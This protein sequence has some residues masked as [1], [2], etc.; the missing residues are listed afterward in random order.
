MSD[1]PSEETL[2]TIWSWNILEK[3]VRPLAQFVLDNWW[4]A[5]CVILTKKRLTLHTCGW[6]GNEEI[7]EALK[8]N[9]LFWSLCWLKSERGG[10]YTFEI[11][12][13]TKS[14]YELAGKSGDAA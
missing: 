10:H 6:S 3:G 14:P 2:N 9:K 4:N 5:D 8:T 13:P 7:V 12:E 11:K 1:Y